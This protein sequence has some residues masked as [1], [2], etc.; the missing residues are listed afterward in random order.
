MFKAAEGKNCHGALLDVHRR[1]VQEDFVL[2]Y[3]SVV[4]IRKGISTFNPV[5]KFPGLQ[6]I[7]SC[8][9]AQISDPSLFLFHQPDG[10][11]FSPPALAFRKT[12]SGA[13]VP[14]TA[15]FSSNWDA[16][17]AKKWFQRY[18]SRSRDQE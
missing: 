6:E 5:E 12:Q 1:T 3:K 16:L 13:M 8:Q 14:A 9:I 2:S 10:D 11:H 7:F 15:D 18:L 4:K 17:S